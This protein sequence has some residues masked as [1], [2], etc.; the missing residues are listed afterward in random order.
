MLSLNFLIFVWETFAFRTV[1]ETKMVY[2][3][4]DF[5]G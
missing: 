1:T 5:T 4:E 3:G 2:S